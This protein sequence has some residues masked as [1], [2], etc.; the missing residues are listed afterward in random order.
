MYCS[1]AECRAAAQSMTTS[2]TPSATDALVTALIERVSRMLDAQCGVSDEYFE[3]ALYPVWQSGHVYVVG[4]VITPTT[5]NLHKYR[6]TTAGTSGATE[7]TFP[8][9]SAATVADGAAVVWTENGADV[10]AS[11]RTFYGDGTNYLKLDPY[12]AG[13]LNATMTVP[14]GYT[15]P[16]YVE[17]NGYLILS[18]STGTLVPGYWSTG[19]QMGFPYTV[20]ALWGFASTPADIKAA[21]IEWIINVWRETDP[22]GLKLV[23]LDGQVLRENMPPRVALIA[24]SWRV[25]GAEVAF[26]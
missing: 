23:G 9:G 8:T 12:V 20:T 15:A 4:D 26:A 13:T 2:A 22:A 14:T 17:R 16:T 7:P 6:C 3:P 5:R 1:I 10:I 11:A 19:W 24:K 21:V 25:K 18:D